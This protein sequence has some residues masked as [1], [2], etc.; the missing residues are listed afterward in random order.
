VIYAGDAAED[1][2][3]EQKCRLCRDWGVSEVGRGRG[4]CR[5]LGRGLGL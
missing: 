4:L 2:W 5:G 3:A 1:I